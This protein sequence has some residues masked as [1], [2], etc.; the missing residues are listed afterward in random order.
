MNDAIPQRRLAFLYLSAF[1]LLFCVSVSLSPLHDDWVYFTT[2]IVR[3]YPSMLKPGSVFWGKFDSMFNAFWRPLD[4][5]FGLLLGFYPSAF[6]VANQLS[7]VMGHVLNAYFLEKILQHLDINKSVRLF[8]VLFFLYSPA[9]AATVFNTDALNGAYCLLFGEIALY[10]YLKRGDYLYLPFLILSILWKE[11]G[12]SW[13]FIIP[14]IALYR[15][16]RVPS[17][18]QKFVPHCV[19]CCLAAV[20]Y[21]IMRFSLAGEI[22]L[23]LEEGRYKVSLLSIHT[24]VNLCLQIGISITSIDSISLFSSHKIWGILFV[25]LLSSALFLSLIFRLTLNMTKSA[26]HTLYLLLT[27]I[28]LLAAPQCILEHIGELQGYPVLFGVTVL[29]CYILNSAPDVFKQKAHA[30]ILF[31]FAFSCILSYSHKFFVT[32]EYSDNTRILAAELS[33]YYTNPEESLLIISAND[34]KDYSVFIE[35]AIQGMASGYALRA[36]FQWPIS[37]PIQRI[38]ATEE[39]VFAIYQAHRS[40][41][42]MIL[43]VD[44]TNVTKLK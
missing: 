25:T 44:G 17:S 40:E 27:L 16:A 41:Y 33:G 15:Y 37:L 2:P 14:L 29:F 22:A 6:P 38:S 7:V 1:V 36:N 12:I 42:D 19:A 4:T 31:A 10:A 23:G 5:L 8:G 39:D 20:A 28:I 18:K 43:L 3:F 35:P 24:L 34:A 11:S 32:R 30:F 9:S 21:F 13:F 26:R